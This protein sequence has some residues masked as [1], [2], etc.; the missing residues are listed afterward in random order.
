MT[1]SGASGANRPVYVERV[2]AV[3]DYIEAHLGDD[4]TVEELA[5]VAH[6][7]PFHFHRI[8]SA[9]TGETLGHFIGRLRRRPL[10]ARH[11]RLRRGVVR[12][13]WWLAS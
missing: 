7:S 9:M 12:P 1:A 11:D 13:R 2:N 3:I 6:F 10:R 5:E 8:F 4:L